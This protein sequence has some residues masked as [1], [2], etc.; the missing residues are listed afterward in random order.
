MMK[1]EFWENI[2]TKE[3]LRVVGYTQEG[4][5]LGYLGSRKDLSEY[6]PATYNRLRG[7]GR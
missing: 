7:G 1:T 2:Y 3:V 5:L 4:Y 6:D